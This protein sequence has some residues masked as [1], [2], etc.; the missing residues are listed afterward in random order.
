MDK[1]QKKDQSK[2]PKFCQS[3]QFMSN[4]FYFRDVSLSKLTLL[5]FKTEKESSSRRS[6]TDL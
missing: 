6:V 2:F 3:N 5:K 4:I 1:K